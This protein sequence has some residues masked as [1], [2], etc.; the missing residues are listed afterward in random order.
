MRARIDASSAFIGASRIG[1]R[2]G[3]TRRALRQQCARLIPFRTRVRRINYR[4]LTK[5]HL[6]LQPSFV[7]GTT[8]ECSGNTEV[9]S[10]IV[11][12]FFFACAMGASLDS[13]MAKR[14]FV[15]PIRPTKQHLYRTPE[16]ASVHVEM[17]V[18]KE[19]RALAVELDVTL[20]FLLCQAI[21][22]LFEKHGRKRM[23]EEEMPP[24]GG[25]AHRVKTR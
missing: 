4:Q 2:R 16:R 9:L 6:G 23:T 20:Q 22:D 18:R 19:L 24:R 14:G 21:N 17:P 1:R 10:W 8:I 13:G 7:T 5:F 12:V 25:A 11:P 3:S 15:F